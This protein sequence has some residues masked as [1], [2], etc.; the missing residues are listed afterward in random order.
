[1][2]STF[3]T[4]ALALC[5]LL[6]IG[7]M[8][9]APDKNFHIYL[10]LGQS[11][12]EGAAR[13]TPAD[14][15]GI[16][17]RFR[18]MS[19]MDCPDEGRALGKWYT[20]V[21]PLAQCQSGIGP[22]DNFGRTMV[23]YLPANVKVGVIVVAV[24]GCKIEL[25]DK[26]GAPAYIATAPDWM[27]G[28]IDG[29]GGDPYA[30]L[31]KLAK[32][33]Q[34]EGVI[35]GIL[36]HQG[37]SNTGEQDWPLKVKKVYE[38]L[39]KDL[40]LKAA[41]VPLLAGEVVPAD[42]R[43]VC[44]AMNP[45]IGELPRVIPTAHVI[46]A[47]GCAT[48]PDNLHFST[49]GYM[50]LGK[51]YAATM[52]D[53]E[54][55]TNDLQPVYAAPAPAP[56][57]EPEAVIPADT[58]PAPTNLIG[59]E[60]PRVDSRNRAYFRIYAPD[61]QKLQVDIMSKKY[62]MKKDAEGVWTAVT[63]SLPVGFH[64]YALIVDGYTVSDP[65]SYTF[66]GASR[67]FSGIEIPEG[68]EGD[69]YR[70]Q[71]VP[72]GQVRE[73]IYYSN[74]TEKFRR[75]YVYT[76]AEYETNSAARYPVLYLQ[77]GMGEDQTGWSKQGYM[78]HI[79]DNFIAA[80]KA[81]PMIVVM[82]SGDIEVGFRPR[83]GQDVDQARRQYGATF[84]RVMTDELIPYIDKTF[85]TLTDRE[86]RAMA[87][88]SWGGFQTFQTVLPHID[89]FSYMGTF[90][91]AIFGQ[92]LKSVYNGIFA[93]ATKFNKQ[94]HYFFMGMGSEEMRGGRNQIVDGLR[95][96]GIQ[97]DEYVSPGTAH[98]WLTWRRCLAQFIPHLFQ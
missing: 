84:T 52:L 46:S 31:V 63:D 24:G 29:Y 4:I 20:A 14:K 50:E 15:Q 89:K 41:N 42:Q 9:A 13:I 71:N 68:K 47:R 10:C 66:F 36:L 90:S 48:G 21:P 73:C 65:A 25:F 45:I 1:M 76:P 97:V 28:K 93:D 82:E 58:K 11:N 78:Q 74:L 61:A 72:H 54:K 34:K 83:R 62:D 75:I 98:E 33:A 87:G 79:M 43:G 17:E 67:D 26:K 57:R 91:G 6:G 32:Q 7:N 40:G 18:M 88:L 5:T 38:S 22:A 39:L 2:K 53:L 59:Q 35:K 86:H 37:E 44:A 60:F 51:R 55:V 8:A 56:R 94:M 81:V 19:T 80:G 64:Y 3:I 85:R 70:P 92:D 23:Q 49:A 12:M 96:L 27:K 16:S 95:A 30:R 69:Y 77:H